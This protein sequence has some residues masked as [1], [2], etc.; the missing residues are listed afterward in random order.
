MSQVFFNRDFQTVRDTDN[1]GEAMRR[2]L[3]HRVSDLPIVDASNRLVGILKLDHLLAGLLPSAALVGYGVP[4]LAFVS[5]GL[6]TLRRKMRKIDAA[7][8]GEFAVKPEHVVY[9]DTPPVEVV[10]QLYR[11]ANN[12][13]VVDRKSGRLLGMVSPRD[14]LALLHSKDAS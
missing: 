14:I 10:R 8:V 1:V 7:K 2:M 12:L 3:E 11:G 9:P 13:P 5:T 6:A 4:D